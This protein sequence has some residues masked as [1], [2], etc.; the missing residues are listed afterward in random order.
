MFPSD[1]DVGPGLFQAYWAL[2]NHASALRFVEHLRRPDPAEGDDRMRLALGEMTG[3][4]YDRWLRCI[5]CLHGGAWD[6]AR[7]Y[8]REGLNA[9]ATEEGRALL[10]A[11]SAYVELL[12]SGDTDAAAVSAREAFEMLPWVG[13]VSDTYAAVLI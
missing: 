2:G 6:A 1:R 13:L 11:L 10:L 12:G 8:V 3:A 9:E 7:G 5:V 4:R